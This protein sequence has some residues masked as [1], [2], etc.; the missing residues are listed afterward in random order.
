MVILPYILVTTFYLTIILKNEEYSKNI[1]LE[2]SLKWL[3][4][5]RDIHGVCD[6][7]FYFYF[8]K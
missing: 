3:V 4:L 7:Y 6:C 1:F 5:Q 8:F 2:L